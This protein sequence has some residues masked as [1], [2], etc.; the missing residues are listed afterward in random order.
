MAEIA[1]EQQEQGIDLQRYLNIVRRRHLQF[2]IPA[3]LGWVIVWS[4][5]WILQP[6]YKSSTQI[7]VEH[8][9][10]PKD[11]VTPNVNDD[12]QERLH[13]I[14]QQVLSRTRLL[15]I[16]EKLHLYAD[17]HRE[18]SPDEKVGMMARDINLDLV[19]DSPGAPINAFSISFSSDNPRIA[20]AVATEL[21]DQFINE[22]LKVRE[23][24]S[25]N[26]T[27]FI[28]EQVKI[29]AQHL[30]DQEAKVR[31]F[32]AAHEG[33]LPSQQASNLQIL[34][35]LQQQLQNEEDSLSTAKQQHEFFQTEINQYQNAHQTVR[36]ADGT[37]TGLAGIDQQLEQL[38]VKLADLTS[39]YTD[40]Y[41]DV[42]ATKDQIVKTERRRAAFIAAI[43][44]QPATKPDDAHEAVDPATNSSL[45]QLQSQLRANQLAIENRERAISDLKGR[46]NEYQAR[47]NAEPATEQQLADL[48]RGYDQSKKD[49]DDLVQKSND[50]SIATS[51]EQMQQ[52]ERFTV[53]DPA[54]LPLK[55]DFPNRLKFCALGLGVG[56]GLGLAV[57]VG[58]EFLDDRIHGDGE[59]KKLLQ[60]QVLSEIPEVPTSASIKAAKHRLT[61]G[62]VTAGLVIFAMLAGSAFSYLHN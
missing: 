12:L 29:A 3:F 48:N 14:K 44:N 53:L 43:K 9:T 61:L 57:V 10:M 11:Y 46:I 28:K 25:E 50:S 4:L 22:N 38:R 30:A 59:I 8:P 60:V 45:M 24:L 5:S 33:E 54:P 19:Q 20:Q 34:S 31:T 41:P 17:G 13:S 16:I 32:Q 37:P 21:T 6:R 42:V 39:R 58:L 1:E 55:P 7:L 52:G 15:Q 18:L 47:L 26:T 40:Q 49:Y 23:Q 62:W 36:T 27:D 56:F 2:L 35:G 51:M